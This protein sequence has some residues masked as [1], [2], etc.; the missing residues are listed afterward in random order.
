MSIK[1]KVTKL[2]KKNAWNLILTMLRQLIKWSPY[3]RYPVIGPR[4][5]KVVDLEPDAHTQG[6]TLNINADVT[7]EAQGVVL[8]ID[9]M[10]QLIRQSNYRAIMNKCLCRSAY[11]CK[12]FP[13]NH[14]CIFIGDG[15]RGIVKNGVGREATVEEAIAHIDRGA[16]LGLI[17]QALWVEVERVIMGLKR[18]KDVAH[19]LEICFCCPCCCGTFKLMRASNLNDIKDR[20][21]SIGWKAEV[22]EEICNQCELCIKN[23][24]V[25]A[26]SLKE[27]RILISEKNCLG[28]GFCAAN[29]SRHAIKL[30]LKT[31]LLET[32]QDYFTRGGLNVDI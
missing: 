16:E 10:K 15:A 14:A 20:F 28:C 25:Q 27:G 17:G 23:C 8:P 30:Q 6:Y 21:N 7:D 26:I 4:L 29:C 32:V 19:W 11:S 9:M 3:F 1:R 5:R 12:K 24:P 18:E 22:K 13:H 31:P 2:M